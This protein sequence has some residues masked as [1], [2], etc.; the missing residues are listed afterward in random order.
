M[1]NHSEA[2]IDAYRNA[3]RYRPSLY[4]VEYNIGVL[5]ARRGDLAAAADHFRQ[6]LRIKP[7]Y[8]AAR[9]ALERA[10][11][12]QAESVRTGAT[13]PPPAPQH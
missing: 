2:A 13:Q 5:L 7:D 8:D 3:L 4:A 9:R 1:A 11:A 6:A 12:A 10:E